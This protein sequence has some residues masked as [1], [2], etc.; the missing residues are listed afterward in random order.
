MTIEL[1]SSLSSRNTWIGPKHWI[2]ATTHSF[3]KRKNL[4]DFGNS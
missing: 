1:P 2:A 3:F 4:L